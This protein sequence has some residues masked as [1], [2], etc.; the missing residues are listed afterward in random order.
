MSIDRSGKSGLCPEE[1]PNGVRWHTGGGD[2]QSE[3]GVAGSGDAQAECDQYIQGQ[4]V[5][6]EALFLHHCDPDTPHR[7]SRQKQRLWGAHSFREVSAH[8]W[9]GHRGVHGGGSEC[10]GLLT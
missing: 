3:Q 1:E 9:Q 7:S 10:W 8:H 5:K 2:V 6:T 4:K